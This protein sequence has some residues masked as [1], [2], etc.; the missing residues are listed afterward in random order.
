MSTKIHYFKLKN[1]KMSTKIQYLKRIIMKKKSSL[2][3]LANEI[4]FCYCMVKD[5]CIVLHRFVFFLVMKKKKIIYLLCKLYT[6]CT[7]NPFQKN[8]SFITN[9]S[10]C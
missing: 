5:V 9:T 4:F 10:S 2:I 6:D 3:I 1:F 7:Y 8:F